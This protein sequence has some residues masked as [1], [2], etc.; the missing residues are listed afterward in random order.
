VKA[1]PG[2]LCPH[3]NAKFPNPLKFCGECGKEMA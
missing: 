1:L 3:C 2:T